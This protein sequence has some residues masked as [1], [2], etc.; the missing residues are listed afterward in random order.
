MQQLLISNLLSG[1]DLPVCPLR[2]VSQIK[3]LQ[4]DSLDI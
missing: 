4:Q 1:F 2:A 3:I